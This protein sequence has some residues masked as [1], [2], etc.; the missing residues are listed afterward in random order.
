MDWFPGLVAA[1][2]GSECYFYKFYA[3]GLAIVPL[4]IVSHLLE[5]A[6]S[7]HDDKL[8]EDRDELFVFP[9]TGAMTHIF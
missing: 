8:L 3:I 4:H 1:D 5:L 7:I 2:L 9:C 6:I